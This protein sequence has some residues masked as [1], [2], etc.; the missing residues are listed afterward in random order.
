MIYFLIY[1]F[2]EVVVSVEIASVIGALATFGVI[3]VTALLGFAILA[4]FRNT[5]V[6]NLKAM[7]N[8]CITVQEF[9]ELNL[10]TLLG[11]IF[12]ILP[13]F[14]GD[15]IGAMLQFGV[16]TKMIANHF[17]KSKVCDKEMNTKTKDDDVIDVEIVTDSAIKR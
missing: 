6:E 15:I 1:L 16:V 7:T 13:G 9:Q 8:N 2:L 4:N 5:F 12:L 10:F 14:L 3:I 17:S 11:A